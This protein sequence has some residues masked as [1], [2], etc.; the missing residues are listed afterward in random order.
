MTH[1]TKEPAT[2]G[3]AGRAQNAVGSANSIHIPQIAATSQNFRA[4]WLARR[5]N[6]PT[7]MAAAVASL[8]FPEERETAR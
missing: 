1:K 6:L 4:I 2:R 8:A 5:F 7:S 3:N